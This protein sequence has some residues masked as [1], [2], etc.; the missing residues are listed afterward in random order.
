MTSCYLGI[1]F[2][3]ELNGLTVLLSRAGAA[4]VQELAVSELDL[5]IGDVAKLDFDTDLVLLVAPLE[6]WVTSERSLQFLC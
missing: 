2:L 3:E 6:W 5:F 1:E 4:D